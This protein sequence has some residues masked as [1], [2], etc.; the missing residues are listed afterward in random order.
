[1]PLSDTSPAVQAVWLEIQSKMTPGQLML[2]A[3]ETTQL[4][5]ELCKAGIR[6]DHP[7]WTEKQVSFELLRLAF[8]P[9]PL[10][11]GLP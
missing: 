6:R 4:A 1:M 3:I 7:D 11:S 5:R 8:F 2:Q 9:K 10:P